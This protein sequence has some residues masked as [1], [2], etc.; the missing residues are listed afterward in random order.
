MNLSW[1]IDLETFQLLP[2]LRI[3]IAIRLAL[4]NELASWSTDLLDILQQK[5]WESKYVRSRLHLQLL[6]SVVLPSY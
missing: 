5:A 4:T 1:I 2:H 3:D 6:L